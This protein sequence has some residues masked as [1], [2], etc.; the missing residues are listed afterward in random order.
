MWPHKVIGGSAAGSSINSSYY[1]ASGANNGDGKG[2][3]W[4]SN[5]GWNDNTANSYP[6]W[7]QVDFISPKTINEIDVFT[8]QDEVMGQG[9]NW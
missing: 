3:N 1:A 2:Q 4:G 7:L 5:G 9:I 6:D 8:V